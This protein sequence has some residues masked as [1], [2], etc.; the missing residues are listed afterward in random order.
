MKSKPFKTSVANGAAQLHRA[1]KENRPR[2]PV[3][4]V[5]IVPAQA[6]P[7]DGTNLQLINYS[8][9]AICVFGDTKP[10]KDTLKT[11]GGKFNPALTHP[12]LGT[13][14]AG[15]IFSAKKTNEIKQAL[16]IN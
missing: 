1:L 6:A 8:E 9:K 2:V 5:A 4:P 16:S 11:L 10:V 15:W 7:I 3:K 12:K 13:R 14:L